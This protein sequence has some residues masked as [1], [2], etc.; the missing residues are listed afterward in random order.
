MRH[1]VVAADRTSLPEVV[2]EAGVLVDPEDHGGLSAVIG[3][4]LED[5]RERER[6]ERA[7][8]ERAARFRPA[9]VYER[10]L[11]LLEELAGR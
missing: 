3:R 8:L 9:L 7:G 6:L 4:I 11:A 5:D 10:Q 1:P 2:G